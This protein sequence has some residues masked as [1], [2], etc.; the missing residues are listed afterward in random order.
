MPVRRWGRELQISAYAGSSNEG[1]ES[2]NNANVPSYN[3]DTEEGA[4]DKKVVISLKG[5][6]KVFGPKPNAAIELMERGLTKEQIM[7]KTG[8]VVGL[9]NVNMEIY[10]G[11][12]FVI[13]GLSGAGKS[14]L[15]RCINR[16]VEPTRGEIVVNDIDIRALEEEGLRNFRRRHIGMVFQNFGLLPHRNVLDNVAFGLEVQ[17]MPR[18][19]RYAK[20]RDAKELV[21]LKGYEMAMPSTLSG[22]MKQRVGLARA[23]ATDPAILLMDEAFSALDPLIR[24][25]MQEELIDIHEQLRK[26]IVF[27]THDL[28]EA[29]KLGDRIAIMKDG[30][31]VQIGTPE[32]ILSNPANDYVVNFLNGIDRSKVMTCESLMKRPELIIPLRTGPHTAL[33]MMDDADQDIGFV[34]DRD[35]RFVGLV[36]A[37]D[38]LKA[39]KGK[40][41][42]K[43]A[44]KTTVRAVQPDTKAEE[45]IAILVETDY[46]IPVLNEQDALVGIIHPGS[47]MNKVR[48]DNGEIAQGAEA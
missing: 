34:A 19:R 33:K 11:E 14:T 4:P 8:S 21:G 38:L 16:L 46:P 3:T 5:I 48:P 32:D 18:E 9:K 47:V 39:I 28:D 15:E 36:K 23:L 12:I 6:T 17:G 30:Q 42:L 25:N 10:E 2:A 26:T 29:L 45:L 22:G 44:V 27:V 1:V 40:Y 37:G 35:K 24:N 41:P 7:E 43:A 13:I 31:V 20:A